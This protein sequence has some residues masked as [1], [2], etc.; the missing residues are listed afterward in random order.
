MAISFNEAYYLEQKLAQL[1]QAG[2]TGFESTADVQA[3]FAASGLTA[4]QHYNQFGTAEG[5]NPSPEFNTDVYLNQKLAQ[6]QADGEEGFETT[7]DVLAAF[8]NAGLSPLEHYNQFG[9]F[10]AISPNNDFNAEFYLEQKLAQLQEAGETGFETTDDVLAAFQAAGL[11]PLDHYNQFGAFEA[12]SPSNAFNT[13]RY[14]A[15]KLAQLQAD[16]ATAEEWAGQTTADLLASFQS[17]GLTPLE[18]FQQFGQDEGLVAQP[19]TPLLTLTADSETAEAGDTLSFTFTTQQTDLDEVSYTLS[20]VDAAD[21]VGGKLTGTAQVVDG[22]AVIEVTLR[23]DADASNVTFGLDGIDVEPV[24]VAVDDSVASSITVTQS[25]I[26]NT[27]ADAKILPVDVGNEGTVDVTINSSNADDD[28]SA[29]V[30]LAGDANLNVTSGSGD[31]EI[32]IDGNGNNVINAGA[33]AD[34]IV[35][36]S[37]NDIVVIKDGQFASGSSIEGGEGTNT[38]RVAGTNDLTTGEL[39]NIQNVLL[40]ADAVATLDEDQLAGVDSIVATAGAELSIDDGTGTDTLDLTDVLSGSLSSLTIANGVTV[41]LSAEQI[42]NI[43]EFTNNGT[44]VTDEAGAQLLADRDIDG[45]EIDGGNFT[46]ENAVTEDAAAQSDLSYTVSTD[47][48]QA[49]DQLYLKDDD[50][51]G[52]AGDQLAD[53]GAS[54]EITTVATVA[55]AEAIKAGANA[56][57][58]NYAVADTAANIAASLTTGS[59]AWLNADDIS[60]LTI[61]DAGSVADINEIF[62]DGGSLQLAVEAAEADDSDDLVIT[63]PE[64]TLADTAANLAAAASDDV[65]QDAQSITL[66]D[67]ATVAQ[68]KT[69]IDSAANLIDG[70]YSLN[71]TASALYGAS[72]AVRNGATDI[73]V[74]TPAS[75]VQ[76][77]RI[78]GFNNSGETSF[79]LKDGALQLFNAP[80]SLLE[81]AGEV[82]FTNGATTELTVAQATKLAPYL[83]DDIDFVLNDSGANLTSEAGL[84]LI[85]QFDSIQILPTTALTLDQV[86]TLV[87]LAPTNLQPSDVAIEDTAENLLSAIAPTETVDALGNSTVAQSADADTAEALIDNVISD[88]STVTAT[89]DI[90]IEQATQLLDTNVGNPAIGYSLADTAENLAANQTVVEG[91]DSITL[92]DTATAAQA[93]TLAG[94][95][96]ADDID[97]A[98]ADSYAN[99]AAVIEIDGNGAL[100]TDGGNDALLAATSITLTDEAGSIAQA[101][102]I[103]ALNAA[104]EDAGKATLD[105]AIADSVGNLPTDE[106]D[107]DS[108]ALLSGATSVSVTGTGAAIKAYADDTATDGLF[109]QV[110]SYEIVV[111]SDA[112]SSALSNDITAAGSYYDGAETISVNTADLTVAN[113]AADY[114]LLVTDNNADKL[115]F[116]DISDSAANLQTEDASEQAALGLADAVTVASGT[117]DVA[118]LNVIDALVN[119]TLVIDTNVTDTVENLLG[120]QSLL[121]ALGSG[122]FVAT[123]AATVA[124]YQSLLDLVTDAELSATILNVDISDTITAVQSASPELLATLGANDITLQAG[125]EIALSVAQAAELTQVTGDLT[126]ILLADGVTK[127]TYEVVDTIE[128]LIN[129]MTDSSTLGTVLTEAS[130]ITATGGVVIPNDYLADLQTLVTAVNFDTLN[131]SYS[132]SGNAATLAGSS[133][134]TA[135]SNADA[136]TVTDAAT[137]SQIQDIQGNN[138]E[139]S[140]ET[141]SDSLSNL[142][143]GDEFVSE[144]VAEIV[145]QA[146]VVT[147]TTDI[148]VAQAQALVDLLGSDVEVSYELEDNPENLANAG[149]LLANAT[150]IDVDDGPG[151]N[152]TLAQFQAILDGVT[153]DNVTDYDIDLVDTAES[154]LQATP[155][156]IAVLDDSGN[157]AELAVGETATIEQ[158]TAIGELLGGNVVL[159]G[160]NIV[161]TAEALVAYQDGTGDD[162]GADFAS[163]TATTT[164]TLAQAAAVSGEIVNT[165]ESVTGTALTDQ[166]VIEDSYANLVNG[167]ASGFTK[168][169]QVIVDGAVNVSK[170][171]QIADDYAAQGGQLANMSF[172]LEE[173]LTYTI[174]AFEE[175]NAVLGAADSVTVDGVGEI[176]LYE[177]GGVNY[178]LGSADDLS[179]YPQALLDVGYVIEDTVANY[180]AAADFASAD[181]AMGYVL[182]DTSANVLATSVSTALSADEI[183]ITDVIDTAT[184][185]DLQGLGIN[186][187]EV[188]G[189]TDSA[190]NL[191]GLTLTA[192]AVITVTDAAIT[193]VQADA[194]DG[195]GEGD[196]FSLADDYANL[197][198][199]ADIENAQA[200]TVTDDISVAQAGTIYAKNANVTLSVVDDAAN[201]NVLTVAEPTATEQAQIDALNV[202]ESVSLSAGQTV[203]VAQAEAL[204]ALEGFDGVYTLSDSAESLAAADLALLEGAAEV[205]VTSNAT[206]A[207]AAILTALANIATDGNDLANVTITDSAANLAAASADLL[208][209][210]ANITIT[211]DEVSASQA[212]ALQALIANTDVGGLDTSDDFTV[213]DTQANLVASANAAGLAGA[214]TVDVSDVITL[215]QARAVIAAAT[216][217]S[218]IDYSLTGTRS[219]LQGA[220]GT[221]ADYATTVTVTDTVNAGQASIINSIFDGGTE[222]AF[223]RVNATFDELSLNGNKLIG[224]AESVDVTDAMEVAE[225]EGETGF[226][227]VVGDKLVGGYEVADSVV[228]IVNAAL[229]TE[230]SAAVVENASNV[231]LTGSATMNIAA[232]SVITS[233]NFT[234]DYNIED[235][236]SAVAGADVA[237]IN[238]ADNV[239][240]NMA[241]GEAET[242]DATVFTSNVVLDFTGET[243]TA[244]A[245]TPVGGITTYTLAN[246][247]V[248]TLK[249]AADEAALGDSIQLGTNDVFDVVYGYRTGDGFV[250]DESLAESMLVTF[251]ANNAVV[252][253][254]LPSVT[255]EDTYVV[256]VTPD[257]TN[258]DLDGELENGATSVTINVLTGTETAYAADYNLTGGD[259]LHVDFTDTNDVLTLSSTSSLAGYDSVTVTNGTL[260]VSNVDGFSASDITVASGIKMTAAQFANV[261]SINAGSLTARVDIAINSQADA[262][263]V[264]T[265]FGSVGFN[266]SG[267]LNVGLQLAEG[268]AINASAAVTA[269]SGKVAGN[270]TQQTTDGSVAT[271]TG[272]AAE[273]K[274]LLDGDTAFTAD[275]TATLSGTS[276]VAEL[277]AIDAATTGIV[278]ASIAETDAVTLAT[279][280]DVNG[281]NVY[282]ATVNDASVAATDLVAANTAVD[283]LTVNA[284][285]QIVTADAADVA[286][287][288]TAAGLTTNAAVTI[289]GAISVANANLLDAETTGVVT[290]SIAVTDA[291]TLATLVDANGNNVYTATIAD[292][293]VDASELNAINDLVDN[294]TVDPAVVTVTENAAEIGTDGANVVAAVGLTDNAAVTITGSISAAS[295]DAIDA[296]TAGTVTFDVSDSATA[297]TTEIVTNSGNLSGA[298]SITHT[299]TQLATTNGAT[300]TDGVADEFDFASGAN[301]SIATFTDTEDLID[302]GAIFA[303]TAPT[304][305]ATRTGSEAV[306]TD[307]NSLGG[308]ITIDFQT[309]GVTDFTIT[310][311]GIADVATIDANDFNFG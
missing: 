273:L 245:G 308:D 311:T 24:S 217:A 49:F 65:V 68:A 167:D 303:G 165:D 47:A 8:Q 231:S 56:I 166:V 227:N 78:D 14:L 237:L 226:L 157:D 147:V 177:K 153:E 181:A 248:V 280:A 221:E 29:R 173:S 83:A 262:D 225:L 150:S 127:A 277:N 134:D 112:D 222:V 109:A 69:L 46:L 45:Y 170:A 1:Q 256:N 300:G 11:S 60:S 244:T 214:E 57:E 258:L 164:F 97:Y 81:K 198:T 176:S 136:V 281:N 77:I 123:D 284:A 206:V 62:Q 143:N 270:V 250:A 39:S 72:S 233:L 21:V 172:D 275:F 292:A 119:G 260:D 185:Q 51:T 32:Y 188:A 104:L 95:S 205:Q 219:Q 199:D 66:T 3:A 146:G 229:N 120:A 212:T 306:V 257:E 236:A 115:S 191:A 269:A 37:G 195:L 238:G 18:H 130:N 190:D 126:D 125:S 48:E 288:I 151:D 2:E 279:L 36:G 305:A 116:T 42:A 301:V 297:I 101:R 160:F 295:A 98:I 278:T 197:D 174:A 152:T 71:D 193:Q 137:I 299:D 186:L 20:G 276:T 293:S 223:T 76:A 90:T 59:A 243:G 266:T 67:A 148:T 154:L 6:L 31:D 129:G 216:G 253:D 155:A 52:I 264:A 149:E 282:T 121:G 159:T 211:D 230:F 12:L 30:L 196:V 286:A 232:A 50:G 44:I 70:G 13:E 183:Q 89:G 169:A 33:G 94:F 93:E 246:V 41:A 138:A 218:D 19:V 200:V 194:I 272:T 64:Y 82:T 91:A 142:L 84:A 182:E 88:A 161:D 296:A 9:A 96:N 283:N 204:S 290:A 43:A 108:V 192:A 99:L 122:T 298:D 144:E 117:P 267:A 140:F 180:L 213:V 202:A 35:L 287:A 34:K 158:A 271:F 54:V 201:L 102:D 28:L 215:T 124:E 189:V 291:A 228:N 156:M 210:V 40:D 105:Y 145:G 235:N 106:T 289:T 187:T 179:Q 133:V 249:G 139:V 209:N 261:N 22:Q 75:V 234:G 265:T 254:G 80:V 73:T 208:D 240:V 110:D 4:E 92:T 79:D 255:I 5:L 268:V 55:Q 17:A 263:L 304:F 163:V 86:Q 38:V 23:A 85:G 251:G 168:A 302:L 307:D 61:T 58:G 175:D 171:V 107:A 131:S 135:V 7:A 241:A 87:D 252:I 242:F 114:D 16:E 184:L 178:L 259:E 111:G 203:T 162:L 274:A 74:N 128:N 103:V 310:L 239:T 309:D 15:D 53:N 285:V 207:E 27:A 26:V 220:T 10:E 141:I 100:T 132:I 113:A 25:Q 118:A 294:L 224:Q 247:D 63:L